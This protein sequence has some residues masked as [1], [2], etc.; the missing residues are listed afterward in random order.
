MPHTSKST[1][2]GSAVLS[3]GDV[4]H[5]TTDK[6]PLLEG[7]LKIGNNFWPNCAHCDKSS[8][9]K[10]QELYEEEFSF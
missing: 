2:I 8:V 10:M 5:F 3:W 6:P 9:T 4:K 7:I 1:G